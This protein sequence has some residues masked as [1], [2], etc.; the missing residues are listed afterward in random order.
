MNLFKSFFDTIYLL[1]RCINKIKVNLTKRKLNTNKRSVYI[2]ICIHIYLKRLILLN[3]FNFT[4]NLPGLNK[5]S[6]I[7]SLLLVIPITRMLFNCSTPSI[8]ARS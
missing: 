3:K 2:F 7:I 8:F 4:S 1:K 6:S 5:A